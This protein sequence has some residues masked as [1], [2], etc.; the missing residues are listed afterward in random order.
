[1]AFIERFPRKFYF[2]E[3]YHLILINSSYKTEVNC[4]ML[5]VTASQQI[6]KNA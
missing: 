6:S 1:M 5:A 4:E 2:F 3:I